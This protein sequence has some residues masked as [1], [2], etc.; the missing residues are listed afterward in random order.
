VLDL[1]VMY[2]MCAMCMFLNFSCAGYT[3][4]MQKKIIAQDNLRRLSEPS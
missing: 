4:F 1:D 3:V 2:I